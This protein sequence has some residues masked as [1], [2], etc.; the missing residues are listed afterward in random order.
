[1]RL[2]IPLG[3]I[4]SVARS[5]GCPIGLQDTADHAVGPLRCSPTASSRYW[6]KR[7][8]AHFPNGAGALSRTRRHRVVEG[9]AARACRLTSRCTGLA[10][11]RFH[12]M[13]GP[14]WRHTGVVW[15]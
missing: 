13:S 1:M 10:T 5:G 6:S 12:L 8:E 11:A 15:A 14:F 4:S 9:S 3:V 7:A 2:L